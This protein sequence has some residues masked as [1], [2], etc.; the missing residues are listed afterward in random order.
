MSTSNEESTDGPSIADVGG[1][2]KNEQQ[3]HGLSSG[4]RTPSGASSVQEEDYTPLKEARRNEEESEED[5]YTEEDLSD[6]DISSA[7]VTPSGSSAVNE[8]EEEE[9]LAE[10]NGINSKPITPSGA[11][12]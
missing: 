2:G 5:Q 6:E 3:N 1:E 9:D 11:R 10:D 4:A 7:Q 12:G 8:E